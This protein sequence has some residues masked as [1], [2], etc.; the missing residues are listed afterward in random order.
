MDGHSTDDLF[1]RGHAQDM[2]PSKSSGGR[3]KS[4]GRS[5]YPGKSLR[6]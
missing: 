6:K 3:S 2:N 4:T 1:V 5:K